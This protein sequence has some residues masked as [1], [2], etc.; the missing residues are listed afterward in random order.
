[1]V[2]KCIP[3]R[4]I[5]GIVKSIATRIKYGTYH[6]KGLAIYLREYNTKLVGRASDI[7][8]AC[9]LDE[10]RT[11]NRIKK[12][13]EERVIKSMIDVGAHIGGYT[14]PLHRK[15]AKIIAIEP[16]PTTYKMLQ[17]NKEI[18]NALNVITLNVALGKPEDR[19]IT[20]CLGYSRS[21]TSSSI[22]TKYSE[23]YCRNVETLTLD[24][25]INNYGSID[26][27]KIDVEGYEL[28]VIKGISRNLYP[29]FFVIE[30][31]I[32][33]IPVIRKI[34]GGKIIFIEKLVRAQVFNIIVQVY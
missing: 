20:L 33:R 30:T 16:W 24:E 10:P 7:I 23:S 22:L 5:L 15:L 3:Y 31:T 21:A 13:A 18:N 28:E 4:G 12:M 6:T 1:M 34:I 17:L 19:N 2:V 27:I 32:E 8:D 11:W 29:R 14:I 9:L 25:I 26:L